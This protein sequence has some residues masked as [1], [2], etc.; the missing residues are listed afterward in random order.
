MQGYTNLFVRMYHFETSVFDVF[1]SVT[2]STDQ[3][4]RMFVAR[5]SGYLCTVAS[6]A[7]GQLNPMQDALA[8]R[9]AP[10]LPNYPAKEKCV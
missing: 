7:L 2:V 9:G 10:Q 3:V 1:A 8:T 6:H 5:H 4:S